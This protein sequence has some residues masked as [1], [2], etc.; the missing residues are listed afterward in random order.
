MIGF[1]FVFPLTTAKALNPFPEMAGTISSFLGFIQSLMGAA[2]SGF[3]ALLFDGTSIPL[4]IFMASSCFLSTGIY[5]LY[6]V[7]ESDNKL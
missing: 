2:T 7:K 5:I 6:G 4:C 3:L 1:S